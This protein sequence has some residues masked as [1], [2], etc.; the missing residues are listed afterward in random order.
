MIFQMEGEWVALDV[1]PVGGFCYKLLHRT[2]QRTP[3][4]F[5]KERTF[6]GTVHL[7]VEHKKQFNFF[8]TMPSSQGPNGTAICGYTASSK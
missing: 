5:C 1:K 6:C 4:K 7:K 8:K 3:T 2:V